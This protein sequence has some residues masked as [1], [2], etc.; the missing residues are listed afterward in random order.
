M[1]YL[2]ESL[3]VKQ[4]NAYMAVILRLDHDSPNCDTVKEYQTTSY[5]DATIW[6]DDELSRLLTGKGLWE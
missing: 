3:V 5:E 2:Y 4:D 6:A 1:R